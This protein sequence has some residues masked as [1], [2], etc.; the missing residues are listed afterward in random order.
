M[1]NFTTMFLSFSKNTTKK[2]DI[3]LPLSKSLLIRYLI[4]NYLY[5]DTILQID[6]NETNDVKIVHRSLLTLK[7]IKENTN[8]SEQSN[9]STIIDIEDCGAAYRFMLAIL[10]ITKGKWL[11]TGSEKLLKRPIDPLINSLKNMGAH[12]Q[13]NPNGIAIEGVEMSAKQ[14]RIDCT[15]SSQFASALLLIAPK[16]GNPTIDIYP[17]NPPSYHYITMTQEVINNCLENKVSFFEGDW[18]AAAF[19]YGFQLLNSIPNICLHPL[20]KESLQHDIEVCHIFSQLGINTHFDD[21]RKAVLLTNHTSA[22]TLSNNHFEFDL[23]NN[24]DLFPILSTVALIYP[25]EITLHGLQNLN[26]KESERLNIVM[27]IFSQFTEIQLINNIPNHISLIIHQRT[28]ELPKHIKLNTF[29]DHRFVMAWSLFASRC[30]V[31]LIGSESVQKS[32]PQFF[33]D[34]KSI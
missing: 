34:I 14:V 30:I 32:Y 9:I 18:S 23:R 4:C 25:F 29:H 16:I 5:H 26:F 19:W 7:R 21:S 20:I 10:S 6:S 12:I 3:Q 33:E 13:K 15:Q 22:E 27:D 28:K 1:R 8:Q 17:T 31:E 24:P 11:L 2:I